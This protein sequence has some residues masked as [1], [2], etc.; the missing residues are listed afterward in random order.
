MRHLGISRVKVR[1]DD[2]IIIPLTQ[3][4]LKIQPRIAE[5]L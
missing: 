2:L 4:L 5:R 3:A 1:T